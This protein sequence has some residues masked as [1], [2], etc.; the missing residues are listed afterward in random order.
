M[1]FDI[2]HTFMREPFDDMSPLQVW[3]KPPQIGASETQIVK[4]MYV[5]KKKKKDIIYTL[6]TDTD[7]TDM[8]GGK[9]NRIIAQNP[10]LGQWTK[11]H[12]SVEQKS[13]GE[14]IIYYRGTFTQK[15]AMMV[16]SQLNVHDEVDASDPDVITQYEN[17]L[18]AN[19]D[20]WRWYFSHP[21]LAGFGVDIYWQ[22][23][24]K[25]E[26]FVH[27]R[28]CG[29]DVILA[30]EE[31]SWKDSIDFDTQEYVCRLC[32]GPF[33]VVD[34]RS[35]Y[36]KATA[37]GI[38]SGY[39]ISQLM[40]PWITAAK[41]IEKYNDP[42]KDEQF[43]YNYVLGLPFV[44]SEN[45]ISSEVV[46]KNL[47]K[48]VNTQ[49]ERIIIGVDTGLPIHFT[50]M[51]NEGVFYHGKCEPPTETHD[52]YDT[53]RS[54]LR[55]W[56]K[57]II[58][59]DQG[60]DLIGIRKL[61]AEFIG[62]VFL[63]YYRKDRKSKELIKW[64]EGEEYGIVVVDRNRMFQLMVEQI[65]D[66]GRIILNGTR[67]D[68]LEWAQQFDN[69]YR[70]VK[71]AKNSPGKDVSTNYGVEFVWKRNGPDHYCHTLLY[72]M[73]GMSKYAQSLAQVI[74]KNDFNPPVASEMSGEIHG[75]R[76]IRGDIVNL[77]V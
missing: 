61:Q 63:V 65:R 24:D 43:F 40:C 12:D 8:A 18:E 4:T 22:Q 2:N 30:S 56:P 15:K 50:C 64:G 23:S 3:L 58:I 29:E 72:A 13:I 68:W 26:W 16:S 25:K 34:I 53:L 6:P 45:K 5:G 47:S 20:G 21:S 57:S 31:Y 7:R 73:V 1:E 77:D 38:F 55:R 36:W 71:T 42:L 9:V 33:D 41:I 51:N 19:A 69:V 14:N 46:L 10:I 76:F 39:H 67:E 44:G 66:I 11:D 52:P 32:K 48:E 59:A 54:L 70:E 75:N 35:G 74:K 62:R 49:S 17:R 37:E 27:C 28:H 60:G